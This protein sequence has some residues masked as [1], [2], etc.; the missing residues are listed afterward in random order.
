MKLQL[1]SSKIDA[2]GSKILSEYFHVLSI[3]NA[4]SITS[5]NKHNP[6]LILQLLIPL[7]NRHSLSLFTIQNTP[8]IKNI[9]FF[10][11]EGR[12]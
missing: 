6:I 4:L 7:V 8:S 3:T 10:P 1:M 11:T 12:E 5:P 9:L 2:S